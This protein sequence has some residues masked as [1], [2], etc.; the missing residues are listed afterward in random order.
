MS[1]VM[2]GI[3]QEGKREYQSQ[4][5]KPA[6]EAEVADWL[7]KR[8]IKADENGLFSEL[9]YKDD[10]CAVAREQIL[11]N[12]RINA[13]RRDVPNLHPREYT[14]KTMVFVAG[15]PTLPQFLDEIK[16]KCED[17]AYDVITSNKTCSYLL[18][19]GI[20]PNFHLILDP[21]ETKLKD[22][23]YE[24]NVDLILGLQCHPKLFEFA[25]EKGRNVH[26]FLAASVTNPDGVSD[27]DMAKD[28]VHEKDEFML[29]I[30]GGSMTGT[31]MIYFAG[32]RGYRRL[33]Y[34]GF[35]GHVV[36]ENN[37][38]KCYAY[39]KLRGENILET[40]LGNG[41]VFHTTMSL[42][43]QADELVALLDQMPGIDVEIYG[44]S[45]LAN[46]L[47]IYRDVNAPARYRITQEYLDMLKSLHS[48]GKFGVMGS[49]SS[50]R[51]FMAA[52]QIL[53]KEGKCR[54][55]DYGSGGGSL[56]AGWEKAFPELPNVSLH[57]YDIA[58]PGKD[59]EPEPAELVFCGDMLEHVEPECV[60]AVLR[61][62]SLLTK[63]IAIFIIALQPAHKTLPDGRN[64][65]ICL[66][67]SDWWMS[68]LRKYF[69][70]VEQQKAVGV[71]TV[72]C[73]ALPPEVH[74]CRQ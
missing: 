36:M 9:P 42:G 40:T 1:A 32:G 49:D 60:D 8:G 10:E 27:K 30:G 29:G 70:V 39:H 69:V 22:L 59:A 14:W 23:R 12:V 52:A 57:E 2:A 46:Q 15:G 37:V 64:A 20:K 51:V 45:L 5:A 7:E 63:K 67:S 33:E 74:P 44:D 24:E 13:A 19:K 56:R 61:H 25:K 66:K 34:Y 11:E 53:K 28:A 4:V 38:V 26:K 72:I 35:D 21:Q 3:A 48:G 58:V 41:R 6:S 18:G 54:V 47:A 16:R 65:H 68:Y 17:D 71:V 43:R 62:I 55:L 73:K 31:R 50:P